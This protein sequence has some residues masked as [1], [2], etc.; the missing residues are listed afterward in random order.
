MVETAKSTYEFC[1]LPSDGSPLAPSLLCVG[2][3]RR[4]MPPW[5]SGTGGS[6]A[7]S[8]LTS[9]GVPSVGGVSVRTGT[10]TSAPCPTGSRL[11]SG[12]LA[13]RTQRCSS[14]IT[15]R[16]RSV[17]ERVTSQILGCGQGPGEGGGSLSGA[18]TPSHGR[19]CTEGW[20]AG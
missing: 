3:A 15:H 13:E 5:E 18:V 6:R 11:S 19:L 1:E 17:R 7:F 12:D 20:E 8:E 14:S 16:G 9:L 2:V 4:L 10:K